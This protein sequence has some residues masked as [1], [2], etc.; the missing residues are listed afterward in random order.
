M[1][2]EIILA[3]AL[4]AALAAP[5][6]ADDKSPICA[7]RPGKATS[8]C[9]VPQGRWQLEASLADWTLQ[10]GDGD[11]DTSL[12]LGETT[13]KYGLTDASDIE[14][15]VT[16]FERSRVSAG[17]IHE[18]GVGDVDVIYKQRLT[19]SDAPLQI[20]AM[21][22][23]KVPT[24]NHSLGNGKWEG[25][26]EF[27]AGY[28]IPKTPLSLGLTPELDWVANGDGHGHHLAMEQVA[29]LGWTVSDKL[30]LSAEIWGGWDWDPAG[31]TRQASADGS[32]AYLLTNDV[33]LDAGANFG[34]N[35]ATPDVEL[36]GG[37]SVRF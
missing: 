30:D 24:A 11:R 37:V 1:K 27:P 18:S 13:L 6:S 4:C 36:Y 22:F 21:P 32:L 15:D 9:T 19:R 3:G 2:G 26:L 34:L 33:Q 31:T 7:D 17:G 28:Q 16:P 10:K 5:A 25:G 29:T 23:I 14:V 8:A 35:S 12:V 20:I